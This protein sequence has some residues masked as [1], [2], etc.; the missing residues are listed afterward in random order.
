MKRVGLIVAYDGTNYCGW[1]VQPNG[2]TIQGELNRCLSEL[3]GEE[4]ETIGASR[5]DAGVHAM[6]NVA[7]FDT[8]TRMPGEKISYALNQRLPEDIRIQLSE[9]MPMDFHPRYCDSVKTYE[10]RIL[11]RRFQIPTERL[12]SYFYHYKL[13]EKKMREAT[14]YLIGRHDF[15]SFCGAGAQVKSTVRTIRS[16]EVERFGDM[17]TIR[18]SG[19]GFLYNMVRIIAGTLIEIGNGQY[20][21]ERMQ[22]ILDARDRE[23]A[24]PTAPAKGLTLLGIQYE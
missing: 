3:L 24:G 5:T 7:V 4:I 21:P 10:Y 18:I 13:D 22:E 17:V 16:V 1:Q 14:S 2:I 19:E 11:N 20:P 6:G 8:E 23:W 15:A 9:E 12:Y